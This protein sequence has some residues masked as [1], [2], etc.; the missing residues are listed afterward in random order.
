MVRGLYWGWSGCDIFGSVLGGE[1]ILLVCWIYFCFVF[2]EY[3]W[4]WE[5]V[6]LLCWWIWRY[7]VLY[8]DLFCYIV[9]SGGKSLWMNVWFD[10]GVGFI[11]R[12]VLWY[13]DMKWIV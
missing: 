3:D 6:V 1:W 11:K 7:G 4:I 9:L 12:R 10:E 13:V 5:N 8:G 2:C